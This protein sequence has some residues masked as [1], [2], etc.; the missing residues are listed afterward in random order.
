MVPSSV[1]SVHALM[2]SCQ[3]HAIAVPQAVVAGI[4]VVTATPA[5]PLAQPWVGGLAHIA[6]GAH[7]LVQPFGSEPVVEAQREVT[8][9]ALQVATPCP[10]ALVVDA[11]GALEAITMLPMSGRASMA[12]PAAWL[13]PGRRGDGQEILVLQPQ[14]L[15]DSLGAAS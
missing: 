7:L 6:G 14:A 10:L 1:T 5:I 11:T 3:G 8:A 2:V 4:A 13:R 12:C 15:A 9:I